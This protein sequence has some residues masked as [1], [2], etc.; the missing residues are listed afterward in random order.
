MSPQQHPANV[1]SLPMQT[2]DMAAALEE[3]GVMSASQSLG[4]NN[5]STYH[6]GGSPTEGGLFLRWSR[7]KKTVTIKDDNSGLL[8]SSIVAPTR[9][10]VTDLPLKKNGNIQKVIL[11]DVSGCAAP[12]EVLAMMG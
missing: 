1:A 12:G 8:R 9:G 3:G 6:G 11:D 4:N 10:S 5:S 2:D 7:V